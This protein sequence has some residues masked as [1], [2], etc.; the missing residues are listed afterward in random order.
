MAAPADRP[1]VRQFV[2][3]VVVSTMVRRLR[4]TG[5]ALLLS[6]LCA[7]CANPHPP[8]G[9]RLYAREYF[10]TA[11]HHDVTDRVEFFGV[12]FTANKPVVLRVAD[13]PGSTQ[14]ITAPGTPPVDQYGFLD[15]YYE[16]PCLYSRGD[17]P[18]VERSIRVLA[19]DVAGWTVYSDSLTAQSFACD[20][21]PPDAA[22][23]LKRT[24]N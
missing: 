23:R 17:R 12:G 1:L 24:G 3:A 9:A 15:F 18:T 16:P 11:Q 20:A 7:A 8:P 19:T 14:D 21:P 22:Q 2:K 5:I 4:A 10:G 6:A 13:L